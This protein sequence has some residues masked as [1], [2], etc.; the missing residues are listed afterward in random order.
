MNKILK[1]LLSFLFFTQMSCQEKKAPKKTETMTKYE[2]TEGTSAP[3]GYPMEVYKGGIECEGGDWVNLDIGLAPGGKAWGTINKGMGSS[4]KS[5]PT[6]L[7]FIWMSY[8]E[9]Q[10]YMIDEKID[11]DKI[12]EYFAQG[13]DIKAADGSGSVKHL[14][15][16]KICIGMA[17]GGMV[18][19]WV[20]GIGIQKEIGRYQG[21]KVT[22][23]ESEI[24]KLDSHEN[25]FFRDDYLKDIH[26]SEKIVPLEIQKENKGKAIPMGLWDTYRIR[27]GWQPMFELPE[28]GTLN[29]V[30]DVAIAMVNGEIERF[31]ALKTPLAGNEFRAIP[32]SVSFSVVDANDNIY[33]ASSGLNEKSSLEAFAK[34]F[35]NDSK[36]TKAKIVIRVNEA[37]SFFTIQLQGENGKA[38]F[39]KTENLEM[40]KSNTK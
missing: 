8:M 35:G 9:N 4:F 6:R 1:Y 2:W 33:V 5:L 25:R 26:S 36:S 37:Y 32:R 24:M 30:I 28:K 31:D 13:Y 7:D 16:D 12:K 10:F 17:P 27:Y 11:I 34:I 23:P 15:F 20:A 39:I 19:L 29:A 3:L 40:F 14:N 22:I 38:A 18:V 21:K